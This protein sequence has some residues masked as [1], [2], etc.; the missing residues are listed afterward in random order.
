MARDVCFVDEIHQKSISIEMLK[1]YFSRNGFLLCNECRNM[2]SL[3]T[4]GGDWNSIV[5]LIE[6][7]QVFYSKLYKGRVTYLSR[8]FYA[9]IKPYRQRMELLSGPGMSIYNLLETIGYANAQQIKRLLGLSGKEYTSA[10]LELSQ[11][12]LV[13]A[14]H[15]DK[16][17]NPN[18]SSFL[19]GTYNTWETLHPI[20]DIAVSANCLKR[21]LEG[22]V[23]EKEIASLL[24]R[25]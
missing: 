24:A 2:P 3:D 23:S 25:N 11:E 6:D 7:G 20:S 4:V 22:L 15:R 10:M 16:T 14:I 21:L 9:Q 8:E 18:W 17:M 1:G 13:T 19:W 12:L 5:L